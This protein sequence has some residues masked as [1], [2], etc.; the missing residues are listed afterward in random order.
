MTSHTKPILIIWIALARSCSLLSLV[1]R[2][3]IDLVSANRLTIGTSDE[4]VLALALVGSQPPWFDTFAEVRQT[5]AFVTSGRVE[6]RLLAILAADVAG[7][8]WLF[9]LQR[10]R[11][12]LDRPGF[13][14]ARYCKTSTAPRSRADRR[15]ARTRCRRPVPASTMCCST[16]LS[17]MRFSSSCRTACTQTWP[18][19]KRSS[20]AYYQKSRP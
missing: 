4:W 18:G 3:N 9:V 12:S 19:S 7:V 6:R 20:R 5:G 17:T 10:N 8:S 1:R 16:Q 2:S 11:T 15:R 13:M 14:P